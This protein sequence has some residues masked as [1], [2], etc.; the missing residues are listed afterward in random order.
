MKKM[1]FIILFVFLLFTFCNKEKVIITREFVYN[2][3]WGYANK[4][5]QLEISEIYLDSIIANKSIDSLNAFEIYHHVK[6]D[7]DNRIITNNVY[8]AS[9]NNKPYS[10][11]VISFIREN[12]GIEWINFKNFSKEKKYLES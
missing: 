3:G 9:N 1:K 5:D 2:S 6:R 12:K 11:K 7:A 8:L 10:T 4:L